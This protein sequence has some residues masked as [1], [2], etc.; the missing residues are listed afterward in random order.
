MLDVTDRELASGIQE[1]SVEALECLVETYHRP[2]QRY[3]LHTGHSREDAEDLATQTLLKVKASIHGFQGKGTLR[4][5]IFQV[6]YRELL[7]LRRRQTIARLL[8][9]KASERIEPPSDDAIVLAQT[10]DRLPTAQRAAFLL[11]EVE[12]L[13]VEEAAMALGVPPGTIK[14]RCHSARMRLR[15]LLGSTY[16]ETHAEP[17]ND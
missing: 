13:S 8:R 11:T 15:T 6:A 5:W 7:L 16:G 10:L 17:V 4:A 9:P 2:V 14:S 12:G 1:G 3:L